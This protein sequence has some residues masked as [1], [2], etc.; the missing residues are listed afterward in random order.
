MVL[1]GAGARGAYQIGVLKAIAELVPPGA[2]CPF[3]VL[4]GT[5]A[6]AINAAVLASRAGHFRHAVQEMEHVWANFEVG[7]VFRADALSML[8][9]SLHWFA[10]IM[11]GGLGRFNPVSLLD[12][13]PLEA[14]L[15]RSIRFPRIGRALARGQIDALAVTASAYSSARSVTFYQTHN[16][17]PPWSRVRRI[18]R[19]EAIGVEHLMASAAVP[20][21]FPPVKIGSEYYGD[22]SMR[23]R[24]PL[25]APIH[26]GADRLLVI[27]VRDEHPDPEPAPDAPT[28][29]PTLAHLAGYMLD[30]LF[31][32]GLYADLERITRINMMLDQLGSRGLDGS[33]ANLRRIDSMVVLPSGDLRQVA[34][35]HSGELP[36]PLRLLLKGLGAT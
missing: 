3:V 18:G 19:P 35:A 17:S 13:A 10:A 25:S 14:L 16:P 7:H 8:K 34:E 6:G 1:P 12:P 9:S 24:A 15:E 2:P 30:T 36:L 32:D 26:L 20:F 21:I 33:I 23:H 4:S 31:M 11:L 22:G 28:R 27:G 29:P 5:S